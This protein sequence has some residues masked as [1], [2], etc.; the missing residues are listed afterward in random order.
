MP[1]ARTGFVYVAYVLGLLLLV[2][3]FLAGLGI[4]EL[5]HK[6]LDAHRG[7]G[8]LMQILS[9][10]LLVLA[11]VARFRGPLLGMSIALFV[12]MALQSV[13][14]NATASILSALHVLGALAIAMTLREIIGVSR[15]DQPATAAP[16]PR[17]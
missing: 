11:V 4:A 10:V 6:G 7:V 3:F 8:S 12:L 5:G 1:W 9:L 13:W 14:A 17:A 16:P 2:Q 15:A